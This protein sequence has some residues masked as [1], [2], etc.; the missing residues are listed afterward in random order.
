MATHEISAQPRTVTGK[1]VR[2]LRRQGLVPAVL[3]G[4]GVSGTHTL[5]LIA[6]EIERVYAQVGKSAM[7]QLRTQDGVARSV[8]IHHVQHDH[9]HRNLIHVDFLAP[10]MQAELT[11]SVPLAIIGE[12]PAVRDD[13]GLMVQIAAELQVSA[14]PDHLPAV[15]TIDAAA[16]TDVGAHLTAA[17][18]ALPEGVHLA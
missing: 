4:P 5:S 3:Y 9:L 11:V 16:L 12:A 15:L 6:R 2:A 13:D 14:L 1:K 17:E 8:I 7:V 18:V 10:D